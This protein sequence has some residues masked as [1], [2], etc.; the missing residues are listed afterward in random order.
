MA[1]RLDIALVHR[2]LCESRTAAQKA[3]REG[4]ALLGGLPCL[5]PSVLIEA[6]DAITLTGDAPRYVGRGGEKLEGALHDFGID[7]TGC[8]VLDVGASTGGFADCL[9]QHGA[10]GIIAIDVGHGQLHPRMAADARVISVEGFNARGLN[11]Q[12]L[13]ERIG[14]LPPLSGCTVDVSFISLTHILPGIKSVLM[15]DA[16]CCVLVK[17]QFE[18]GPSALDRH[19]VVKRESDRAAALARVMEAAQILGFEYMG[20][21]PSRL[22]GGDGN[23]EKF[24]YLCNRSS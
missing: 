10:H 19:G 3:I 2:G 8:M 16:W 15:P 7:P 4:R 20:N 13:T 6:N 24:V 21:T 18:C 23:V 12:S 1:E 11:A 9:L 5:K 17:P 22:R 14:P